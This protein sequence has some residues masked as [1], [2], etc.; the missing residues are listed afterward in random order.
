VIDGGG[1][2]V[3]VPTPARFAIHKLIIAQERGAET[4]VKRDKDFLQ[5]FQVISVLR[6]ERPGDI[7]LAVDN[8]VQRGP[9]W[10]KRVESGMKELNRR[11]G[12]RL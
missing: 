1:T 12:F 7:S 9:G 10:L 5:A 2:L 6:E 8:A 4:M 11:F 3:N